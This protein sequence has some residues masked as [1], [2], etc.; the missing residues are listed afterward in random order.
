[1]IAINFFIIVSSLLSFYP[2]VRRTKGVAW[3]ISLSS[4]LAIGPTAFPVLKK[5]FIHLQYSKKT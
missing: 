2:I 1:V 3:D 4:A 5:L